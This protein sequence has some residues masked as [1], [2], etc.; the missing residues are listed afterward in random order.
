MWRSW[1]TSRDRNSPR[2]RRHQPPW[3]AKKHGICAKRHRCWGSFLMGFS[4]VV[5]LDTAVKKWRQKV[6]FCFIA[7]IIVF[8]FLWCYFTIATVVAILIE[9]SFWRFP[10]FLF[11]SLGFWSCFF[12]SWVFPSALGIFPCD[13]KKPAGRIFMDFSQ[14][15]W[16]KF[17]EVG[18]S[19][20]ARSRKVPEGLLLKGGKASGRARSQRVHRRIAAS[21]ICLRT[22]ENIFKTSLKCLLVRQKKKK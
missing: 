21:W 17:L 19:S 14:L 2:A 9:W 1:P 6:F 18:G 5:L 4:I 20:L 7:I 15:L 13:L 3:E 10:F 8:R 22:L 16:G 12:S 11:T